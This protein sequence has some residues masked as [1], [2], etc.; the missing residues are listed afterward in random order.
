MYLYGSI[1]PKP[2]LMKPYLLHMYCIMFYN[3]R[4]MFMFKIHSKLGHKQLS[5]EEKSDSFL[6]AFFFEFEP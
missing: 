6:A 2:V 5:Q 1:K 3:A 4:F